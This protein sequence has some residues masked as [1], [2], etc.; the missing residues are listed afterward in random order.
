[1]QVVLETNQ[2]AK[3]YQKES[4]RLRERVLHQR[5]R[6]E[7]ESSV[8]EM[9]RSSFCLAA[10]ELSHLGLFIIFIVPAS[11]I[12]FGQLN[13]SRRG[14]RLGHYQLNSDYGLS[15]LKL[16]PWLWLFCTSRDPR[17]S[18]VVLRSACRVKPG[19]I[20]VRMHQ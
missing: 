16:R 4:R 10:N 1:M 5:K 18:G 11:V 7:N 15:S 3:V 6:A 9:E 14:R 19:R 8:S 2:S 13:I 20:L 17:F 12:C